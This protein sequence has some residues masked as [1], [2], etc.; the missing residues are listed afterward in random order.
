MV[1]ITIP[2]QITKG[3]ELVVV[4]RSEFDLFAK[5][6]AEMRDALDKVARGRAE[7]RAGKTVVAKSTRRFRSA[8]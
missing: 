6:K 3:E 1:T 7:Y 5:W 4:R 2:K 8:A